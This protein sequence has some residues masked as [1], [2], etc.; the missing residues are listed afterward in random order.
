VGCKRI[1][2]S[3]DWY[4][5]ILG[6]TVEMVTDPIERIEPDA[7]VAGGRRR[8]ADVLVFGTGF[9]TTDFLAHL[10]VT[11]RDGRTLASVWSTGVRAY[12][13]TTV[14]G[15]PNCFLLYGPNTNLGHN[16]ILFM[17]ER[18]LNLVLLSL[19]L[20]TDAADADGVGAVEVTGSAFDRDDAEVQRRV[21]QT[22]WVAA[23]HSWYKTASGRVT[24][25]WPSWTVTYWA[26]MLRLP[27][28]DVTVTAPRHDRRPARSR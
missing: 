18:Q 10:P 16:S 23:C 21:R 14:A 9:H 17:V 11:G 3:N 20:Q 19:A 15:F 12:R 13:G 4:P 24:N 1:L 2:I 7:V 28:G 5:T 22:V 27:R 8:P 25:N 6:R 26:E